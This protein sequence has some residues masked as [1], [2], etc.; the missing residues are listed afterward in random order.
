MRPTHETLFELIGQ[1]FKGS[2]R[3]LRGARAPFR[4]I[5]FVFQT[6]DGVKT[7]EVR[8][9]GLIGF[10]TGTG[11]FKFVQPVGREENQ[12]YDELVEAGYIDELDARDLGRHAS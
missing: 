6:P 2:I 1:P 4:P 8:E 10:L 11:H 12:Y 5:R 7:V 9:K 3:S